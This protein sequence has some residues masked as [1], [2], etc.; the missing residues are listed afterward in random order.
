MRFLLDTHVLLWLAEGRTFRTEA[1][2]ALREAAIRAHAN[3]FVSAFSAWEVANLVKKGRITLDAAPTPW[4]FKSCEAAGATVLSANVE[5]FSES[6]AL[7]GAFHGDPADRIITA[8][9][10]RYNL[11]LA[12]RDA[13]I[14]DYAEAGYVDVLPC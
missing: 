3:V 11:T 6:N 2:E 4:F 13:K 1:Q 7:P 14:R 8:T 10:R 5:I 9:A 12:T